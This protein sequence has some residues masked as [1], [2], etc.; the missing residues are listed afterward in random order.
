[1]TPGDYVKSQLATL[2]W[3]EDHADLLLGMTAAGLVVRN[4]VQGGWEG[5]DWL[6]LIET[7]DRYSASPPAQPRVLKLGNPYKDDLFRRVLGIAESIYD[8]REKDITY[9]ALWY[10]RLDRCS[11]D[12]KTKIVRS[13]AHE[14]IATIGLKQFFK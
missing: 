6:K 2:M 5:G 3:N 12:F 4:R 9:G 1:M 13:P 10:G 14:R 8:G 11:D 7:F